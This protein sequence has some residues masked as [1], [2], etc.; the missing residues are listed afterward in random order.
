[1]VK[2]EHK[3]IKFIEEKQLV[4]LGSRI[5]IALSG[6][7]DSVFLLT[8]MV[9]FRSKYKTGLAAFHLNHK[10]RGRQAD[11]DEE[12]CRSLCDELQIPFYS[13]AVDVKKYASERGISVEEAGRMVRYE[14]LKKKAEEKGYDL[15]ATGHNLDDNAETVLLNLIKGTGIKGISGIPPKRENIIRPLLVLSKEEIR[16]HVIANKISSL[17]DKTNLKN[18]YE[19]NYLRNRI[20]PQIK[21]R[22]NPS[23]QEALFRSAE[24]FRNI[25][26]YIEKK[27]AEGV[28][29]VMEAGENVCINIAKLQNI[30]F[31][32]HSGIIKSII[33]RNFLIQLSFKDMQSVLA[34]V[35]KES[36]KE[37]VLTGGLRVLREREHLI[38]SQK[39]KAASKEVKI[40]SGSHCLL[41]GKTLTIEEWA[42][43]VVYSGSRNIE[44]I[45]GDELGSEFT[46][47]QWK[48]GD[49]FTPIGMKGRVKIS[50]FLNSQKVLS[51]DKKQKLV[52]TYRDEIIWVIGYRINEK[53]KIKPETRRILKLCLI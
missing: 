8:F 15:I 30:D 11:K 22:L 7:P 45:S 42:G 24:V 10:L 4:P 9:K 5:L 39:K 35:G 20:I 12:F 34:L 6:G 14:S 41:N 16:E 46:I 47:R 33:E 32:L 29:Q 18:D 13:E 21:E 23:L 48:S 50:D 38:I 28:K 2:T 49:K 36:G 31:E 53:F 43:K 44:Y 27:T 37:A 52:L 26:G 51:S 19:R 1:M 25:A 40:T 3:V 17:S